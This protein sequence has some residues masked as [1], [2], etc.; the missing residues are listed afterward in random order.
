[1]ICKCGNILTEDTTK[2]YPK[3]DKWVK[4]CQRAHRW[5]IDILCDE[6]RLERHWKKFKEIEE[7]KQ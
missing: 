6:C 7:K 3:G 4:F 2:T 5:G 1:M